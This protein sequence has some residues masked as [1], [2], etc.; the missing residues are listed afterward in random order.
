M[1]TFAL[2]AATLLLAVC[3]VGCPPKRPGATGD[4]KPRRTVE[5]PPAPSPKADAEP[6]APAALKEA[7]PEDLP[8]LTPV[9]DYLR[10]KG[11]D[12]EISGLKDMRWLSVEDVNAGKVSDED[13]S[14]MTVIYRIVEQD[15][16]TAVQV[17]PPRSEFD[18]EFHVA[19]RDGGGY[20]YVGWQPMPALEDQ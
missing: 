15:N 17:G 7:R 4:A 10:S 11:V 18:L 8:I 20:L 1:R 2:L 9:L 3:V 6:A 5:P 13:P 14:N 16:R 19:A 12:E